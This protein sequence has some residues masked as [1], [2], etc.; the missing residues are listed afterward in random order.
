MR[1][2]KYIMIQLG[3]SS[4]GCNDFLATDSLVY[5]TRI[6]PEDQGKFPRKS[7]VGYEKKYDAL[8]WNMD[9]NRTSGTV[10]CSHIISKNDTQLTLESDN[11][12]DYFKYWV[13]PCRDQGQKH[14]KLMPLNRIILKKLL[15]I[16]F[17]YKYSVMVIGRSSFSKT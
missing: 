9:I 5:G 2:Q 8:P 10:H 16:N 13:L 11:V 6:I 12:S 15:P 3:Q 14:T 17:E 7:N 4:T 1:P